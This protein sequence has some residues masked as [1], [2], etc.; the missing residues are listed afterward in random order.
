MIRSALIALELCAALPILLMRSLE[1]DGLV[2]TDGLIA[3]AVL[4]A[5]LILLL[6]IVIPSRALSFNALSVAGFVMAE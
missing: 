4:N 6:L 2:D 1:V 5:Q 3:N